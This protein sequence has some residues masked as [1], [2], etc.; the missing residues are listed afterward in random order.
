MDIL[1]QDIRYG[2]KQLWKNKGLS[3]VAIVSLAIGIGANSTIFSLVNSILLRPRAVANPDQLVE[4]YT[5]YP[6]QPYHSAS[7]PSYQE[8]RDRNEVLSGLACYTIRQFKL[9]D[10]NQVEQIWGEPVSGNYFDLLG[11]PAFKG[12]TFF[13]EEN[14]APGQHPVAVVGHALWQ[15]RFNSDP[16]LVGKTITIN[17]QPLTVIGIVPPQYTG[18]FRGLASEIWVPAMM[19]PH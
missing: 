9:D 7:Y 5:G 12:R 17:K 14:S 3:F 13:A 8:L 11:V 18:M 4:I 15:R 6:H 16:E 19:M 10:G 1:I 2:V